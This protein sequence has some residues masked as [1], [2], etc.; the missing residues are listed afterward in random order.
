MPDLA[1]LARL[2]AGLAGPDP[3]SAVF[4]LQIRAAQPWSSG[5]PTRAAL[6]GQACV[7]PLV[8]DGR[9]EASGDQVHDHRAAF[10]ARTP[11]AALASVSTLPS[12]SACGSESSRIRVGP[13]GAAVAAVRP[14]LPF[15][16]LA[17]GA[18]AGGNRESVLRGKTED[19]RQVGQDVFLVLLREPQHLIAQRGQTRPE[20]PAVARMFQR[21]PD[22]LLVGEPLQRAVV[23]EPGRFHDQRVAVVVQ[24]PIDPEGV[25]VHDPHLQQEGNG[26]PAADEVVIAQSAERVRRPVRDA[27]EL[28]DERLPLV[29]RRHRSRLLF[30]QPVPGHEHVGRCH[31]HPRESLRVDRRRGCGDFDAPLFIKSF[32]DAVVQRAQAAGLDPLDHAPDQFLVFQRL[33]LSHVKTLAVNR[34]VDQG[35]AMA[36]QRAWPNASA[37]L[38]QDG[39]HGPVSDQLVVF[40]PANFVPGQIAEAAEMVHQ[41]VASRR[42]GRDRLKVIG[43]QYCLE[44]IGDRD[45]SE[46]PLPQQGRAAAQNELVG[47]PWRH[48][49]PH[50]LLVVGRLKG[51]HIDAGTRRERRNQGGPVGIRVDSE[52]RPV[53]NAGLEQ[54]C[55]HGAAAD[56]AVVVQFADPLLRQFADAAELIEQRLPLL[57]GRGV[58]WQSLRPVSGAQHVGPRHFEALT[59]RRELLS[60]NER[61]LRLIRDDLL[62]VIEDADLE[63]AADQR[64]EREIATITLQFV[65]VECRC[66]TNLAGRGPAIQ[67]EPPEQQFP[68]L[69]SLAQKL[70]VAAI[71][72]RF[73]VVAALAVHLFGI[74]FGGL[75]WSTRAHR[76]RLEPDRLYA[77]APAI[78]SY[79]PLLLLQ[80]GASLPRLSLIQGLGLSIFL[81]QRRTIDDDRRRIPRGVIRQDETA[82]HHQEVLPWHREPPFDSDEVSVEVQ[83]LVFAHQHVPGCAQPRRVLRQRDLLRGLDHGPRSDRLFL[84]VVRDLFGERL[85]IEGL[86]D[87]H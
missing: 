29:A 65:R 57:G 43:A 42:R 84:P 40:Q 2:A 46:D 17:A 80:H 70:D 35:T 10:T 5:F 34:M 11:L 54:E 36:F 85:S 18:A 32:F 86:A 16:T 73:A 12:I 44:D 78:A 58:G 38:Q 53:A 22:K 75:P 61:A 23:A 21:E 39:C 15:L 83:V 52:P 56:Q 62:L 87:R 45:Q 48:R 72:A 67:A 68:V 77:V 82:G 69:E 13:P 31:R 6:S 63:P 14:L 76:V 20:P 81:F 64:D 24:A 30:R 41:G 37:R 79:L 8:V 71:P 25:F 7:S 33:Q 60:R 55:G 1:P 59:Q 27:A 51:R 74:V 3:A 28:V 66:Q 50:Q 4:E 19:R 9:L 26:S 47:R 49:Q